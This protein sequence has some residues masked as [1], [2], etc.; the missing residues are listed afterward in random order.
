MLL[1]LS[2]EEGA[3]STGCQALANVPRALLTRK[4]PLKD[5]SHVLK[6]A[7]TPSREV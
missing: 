5:D 7:A 2:T 6:D 1:D 4:E 3:R